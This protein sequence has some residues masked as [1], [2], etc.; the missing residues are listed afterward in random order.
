MASTYTT[1]NRLERQ[2]TGENQ[3]TWG[4]RLNERTFDMLDESIDGYLS[5][6][7][8]GAADVTL[9]EFEGLTDESRQRMLN[10]TGVLTGNINVIVPTAEHW[11]F[12]RNST[13][14]SFTLT[15][16]TTAGT[17]VVIDQGA[18]VIL[19]CDGTN[20]EYLTSAQ[21]WG[22]EGYATVSGTDTYTATLVP[23]PLSYQTGMTVYVKFTNANT[24][25]A[26]INLNSLGAKAIHRHG[27]VL[28]AGEIPVN[29]LVPL[30]YDGTQFNMP[31]N[32]IYLADLIDTIAVADIVDA[33]TVATYDVGVANTN[34]PQMDATGYPAADGSR[35]TNVSAPL[36]GH[37]DG[38]ILSNDATDPAKDI[39]ISAGEA[40]DDG[41]AVIMS[42]SSAL[43]K[44]LDASWAV[45]TNQG[46]LDGTESVAG[47]PD[48][49]TWYH[50]WLIRRS[51]TGVVD[52]L[53]SE[54][55]TAPTMP[56]NYDQKRRIGAVLFDATPDIYSFLQLGDKFFWKGQHLGLSDAPGVTT[57][58]SGTL[59][60]IPTGIRVQA[61][62][63]GTARG[64]AATQY[65]NL[66]APDFDEPSDAKAATFYASASYDNTEV[67]SIVPSTS[68]GVNYRVIHTSVTLTVY[69]IGWID[70]RGRNT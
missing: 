5:K 50:I 10:F 16:K 64:S 9:T 1:R 40:T 53:A 19:Y 11:W 70:P 32:K 58:Q 39:G 20:V 65:A 33:G 44:K 61:L 57:T 30:T 41:A 22:A 35:I 3:D 2:G 47:T 14:G 29:G 56:T 13:T 7:V 43:I 15:V 51:D 21:G 34:I 63:K 18:S 24:G 60:G 17:G 28:T 12:M 42:L 4:T 52:I 45:G 27:A 69:T 26:T 36:R 48:A 54:S 8:A 37:I 62:L 31:A 46:S 23:A 68:A 6:S 38:L 55:A 59:A 25:A 67:S 49:D 66:W